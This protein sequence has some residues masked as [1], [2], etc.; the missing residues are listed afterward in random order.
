[1]KKKIAY[2][3]IGILIVIQFIRIDKINPPVDLSHDFI[4]LTSPPKEVED[5]FK[6]S[7]YDCHSNESKYPWYS[8]VAPV[9]W[10]VKHHI[11]EGR[12][13][14][15]LSEWGK[16]L[17]EDQKHI[18]EECIEE[19]EEG[20]MPMKGYVLAHAEAD[21]S[22]EEKETLMNWIREELKPKKEKTK[23]VS[24]NNGEKWEANPETTVGIDRMLAIANKDIE[25][26]R[27]SHYA[28]MGEQ[29]GIEMKTIFAECTM[30]GEAHE[31]LHNYLLPL[32]KMFRS[33][34]DVEDEVEAQLY[35]K[36]IIAHLNKY[37]T[38]FK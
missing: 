37:N 5:M 7:C 24:L 34:E 26:G 4:A 3:V 36:N 12:E 28:L 23:T 29:L 19:V 9:S 25:E 33:L 8:N 35:Q 1:M 13:H 27:I 31:Q 16:I 10:A 20:E 14:F 22:K 6:N 30:D 2:V 18:L 21:F 32:V 11:D 15:N 38:Y 17:P